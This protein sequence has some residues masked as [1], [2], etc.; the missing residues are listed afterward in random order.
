MLTTFYLITLL[1]LTC[2]VYHVVDVV[3]WFVVY[4]I[5]LTLY[6]QQTASLVKQQEG[7]VIWRKQ[8]IIASSTL[9]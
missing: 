1:K 5:L 3:K 6:S 4:Y 7:D 2:T 9:Q 8:N